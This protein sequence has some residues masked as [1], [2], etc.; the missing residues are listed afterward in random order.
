M[1]WILWAVL[2][3]LATGAT[4]ILTKVGLEKVDS[5]LGLAIQSVIILVVSWAVVG[6]SGQ[7]TR[8][9]DI[10]GKAW[11]FLIGAGVMTCFAY[12]C[13]FRALSMGDASRVAPV[14][15]LSLVV[16]VALGAILLREKLSPVA[17][18]GTI[19]MA[20]GA[21]MIAVAPSGK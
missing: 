13:Y 8:V 19:T 2:G 3:A 17:I 18:A 15:R 10:E 20:I 12:I 1:S 7:A 11:P 9:L 5:T 4:A 21:I 14:D 6:F 16:S